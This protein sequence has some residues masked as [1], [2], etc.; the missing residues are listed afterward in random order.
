MT[1]EWNSQA[2]LQPS[3]DYW[4]ACILQTGVAFDIFFLLGKMTLPLPEI[5]QKTASDNRSLK[6]L[7]NGLTAMGLLV[8]TGDSYNNSDSSAPKFNYNSH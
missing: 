7:L 1:H 3:S 8:K 6:Y 5:P 4:H 2:L